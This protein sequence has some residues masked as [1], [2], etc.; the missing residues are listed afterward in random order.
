VERRLDISPVEFSL[1]DER[2]EDTRAYEGNYFVGD[3]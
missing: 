2:P 3:V 1:E